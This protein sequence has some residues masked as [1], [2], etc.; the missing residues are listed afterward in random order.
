MDAYLSK[1]ILAEDLYRTLESFTDDNVMADADRLTEPAR[2]SVR[3]EIGIDDSSH[4]VP[5][6]DWDAALRCAAGDHELLHELITIFLESLPQW[7]IDLRQAI[8]A[9]DQPLAKRLAHTLKGS[10]R[11]FGAA[12][13]ATAQSLETAAENGQFAEA[14]ATFSLLEAEIDHL[15]PILAAR[16]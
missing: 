12:A 7:L 4:S 10:L 13:A 2:A 9:Q 16:Q 5:L 1:P 8:D 6:I 11:Q 15:R 3:F 14:A